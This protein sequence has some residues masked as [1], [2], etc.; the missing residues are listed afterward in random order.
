[1]TFGGELRRLR[2][3]RGYSLT[4]LAGLVYYSKGHLSKIENDR[5]LPAVEY[6][7][8]LDA[9]LNADGA[10]VKALPAQAEAVAGEHPPPSGLT[11]DSRHF[12]GRPAEFEALKVKLCEMPADLDTALICVIDGMPGIGKTALASRAAQALASRFSDGVLFLDLHG[13]TGNV[14]P[15]SSADALDRL[16]RRFGLPVPAEPDERAVRFRAHLATGKFLIVLDNA[17][18]AEQVRPLIPAAGSSRLLITSR[19]RLATLDMAWHL[20]LGPLSGTDAERLLRVIAGAAIGDTAEIV[21]IA[22]VVRACGGLPLALTVVAARLRTG[23]TLDDL[24]SSLGRDDGAAA[25]AARDPL[26][27]LAD[28]ERSVT[29]AIEPSYRALPENARGVFARLGL[30]PCGDWTIPYVAALQRIDQAAAVRAMESL[31]AAR[32]VDRGPDGRFRFHDLVAAYARRLASVGLTEEEARAVRLN[33]VTWAVD[34]AFRADTLIE[35]SR[36]HPPYE[37]T[38]HEA[39]FTGE[40]AATEWMRAEGRNLAALCLSARAWGLDEPC[41]QLAFALRGHFFL[42]K[43]WDD[44][45]AT[46]VAALAAARRSGDLIAETMTRNNLGLALLEM[47]RPDAANEHFQAVLDVGSQ[48]GLEYARANALANQGWVRFDQGSW[49]DA[50][51]CNEEALRF[52]IDRGM[53]RNA[54]IAKRSIA[55]SEIELA[56]FEEAIG[57]LGEAL[58]TFV[59]LGLTLNEAMA[60]NCLGE[61]YLR[62]GDLD[63]AENWL[64]EAAERARQSPSQYEEARAMRSLGEIAI[65]RGDRRAAIARW[66]TALYLYEEIGAPEAVRISDRLALI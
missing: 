25:G 10:L 13:Y 63:R 18:S 26:D 60:R 9:V 32:L 45:E 47:G 61:A 41:W 30:L 19:N 42:T 48:P 54:A 29:A 3:E 5:H 20:S 15:L 34:M 44:W 14:P 24:R 1:M 33:A 31:L 43:Q 64:L 2:L 58:D 4:D 49:M 12:I 62:M 35:P 11:F 66:Q 16:L 27:E 50:L 40:R 21:E 59:S 7:W 6:A 28:G 36:Y 8:Q 51:R 52:Y 17:R 57:H 55:L 39:P 22:E 65:T 38:S 37:P 53:Q 46:H 23:T 56:R